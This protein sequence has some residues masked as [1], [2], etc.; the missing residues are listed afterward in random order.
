MGG[1]LRARYRDVPAMTNR[2]LLDR[3]AELAGLQTTYR[4]AWGTQREVPDTSCQALLAL[5]G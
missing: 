3:L 1:R 4:D 2:G 5:M